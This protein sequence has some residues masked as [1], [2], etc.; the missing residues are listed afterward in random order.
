MSAHK[1]GFY[2]IKFIVSRF[3]KCK[4]AANF[5]FLL[6]PLKRN[7]TWNLLFRKKTIFSIIFAWHSPICK[8]CGSKWV[9]PCIGKAPA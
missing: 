3:F 6:T 4:T 5:N 2:E 7:P 9:H 8:I 1:N